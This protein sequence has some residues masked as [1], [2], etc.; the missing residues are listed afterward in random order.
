MH[1][2]LSNSRFSSAHS[3]YLAN[4][5]ST[6]EPQTYVQVVLHLN[7]KKAMDEELSVL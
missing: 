7:W 6:K 4:I 1:H 5:T 3:A 2:F